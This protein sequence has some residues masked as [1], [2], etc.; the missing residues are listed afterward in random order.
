MRTELDCIP[1][2][3]RQGLSVARM[4]TADE[5][6]QSRIL[7]KVLE[8][9]SQLDLVQP[10]PI[11]GRWIHRQARQLA[12][13]ADPYANA[14]AESNQ[15]ALALYPAWK[16]RVLTHKNPRLAALRL[17]I[18]ANVIDFGANGGLNGKKI[19]E[20]LE[21]SFASP[22][23]GNSKE[24]FE[25][26]EKA[27][28]ILFLAD[29]AGELVFDRM[30]L[31]LLAHAK[32]TVVV[33][34]GP[35]I[36]DALV[37]DAQVAGLSRMFEVIDNGTDGAG[38]LLEFCSHRFR[39]RFQDADLVIAKGQAN[40]ESLEGCDKPIFFLFRVK[41]SVASR[42]VGCEVGSLVVHN[43]TSETKR[44]NRTNRQRCVN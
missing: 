38:T 5:K 28:D 32:I 15:V 42:H 39:K 20:L 9:A 40:Y 26:V 4:V 34:G 25:A 43:N 31:E 1:C 33:K 35:A 30:L 44:K 23:R 19:P 11:L 36:N 24:F 10:P 41:C 21:Q 18:A 7:K 3:L 12:K 17:A 8:R 29:N 2:L 37:K 22:F 27:R 14:K 13:C 6:Q 16:K